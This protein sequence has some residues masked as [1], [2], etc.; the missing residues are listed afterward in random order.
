MTAAMSQGSRILALVEGADGV[1]PDARGVHH[2]PGPDGELRRLVSRGWAHDSAVGLPVGAGGQADDRGV[3]R[4]DGAEFEGGGAGHG[5][6]QPC[7]V[8]PGVEVEEPCHQVVG[9]ECGQVGQR[10]V[11]CDLPVSF[12]DA[13]T[14]REVVHPQRGGVGAGHRLGDDSVAAEEGNE[15]R[16][17]ADQ[18]RRIVEQTLALGQILVHQAELTLLQVANAAVN[19]LRGFRGGAGGEVVLLDQGCFQPAAGGIEGHPGASNA[20]ADDQHVELLVGEASQ[21]IGAAKGVH[22]SRLPHPS[23]L[24]TGRLS[25]HRGSR[26]GA[27]PCAQRG[28]GM[29]PK[30]H[31][32]FSPA[33]PAPILLQGGGAPS[34]RSALWGE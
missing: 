5:E 27:A 16:E 12:A 33:L 10:L 30:L 4:H 13:P 2:D 25:C 18:M 15:E 6:C 14:T 20:P 23:R 28:H 32:C 17:R 1:G 8:G 9:A 7:I 11:F 29:V 22:R 34:A 24:Q 26:R 19:H 21:R 31:F 3:V